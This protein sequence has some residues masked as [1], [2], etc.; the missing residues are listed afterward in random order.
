M[1]CSFEIIKFLSITLQ[2]NPSA[3]NGLHHNSRCKQSYKLKQ[4]QNL[5]KHI[6][7]LSKII[8]NI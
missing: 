7:L 2:N 1:T 3:Q 8:Y 5:K 6:I 4:K